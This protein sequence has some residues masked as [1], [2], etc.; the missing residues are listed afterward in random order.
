EQ[1]RPTHLSSVER[2]A[3]DFEDRAWIGSKAIDCP[4]E[5]TAPHSGCTHLLDYLDDQVLITLPGD[6]AT[7]GT[8][9][10]QARKDRHGCGDPDW[11]GLGLGVQLIGLD[12]IKREVCLTDKLGM[13]LFGVLSSFELPV[14][15]GAF[16]K[17][18]GEHNRWDRTALREQ[19]QN[20]QHEP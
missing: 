14:S 9:W 2:I 8:L 3:K 4:Q 16:I 5:R 15:N 17:A 18:K 13:H 12:L 7:P 6:C 11:S 20:E 10:V 1:A 19:G